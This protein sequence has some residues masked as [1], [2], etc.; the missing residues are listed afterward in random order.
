MVDSP[1]ANAQG[2]KYGNTIQIASA[3]GHGKVV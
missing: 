1:E 3:R 2:G